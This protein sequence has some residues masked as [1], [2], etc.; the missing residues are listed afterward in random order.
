M[1]LRDI[2]G[3]LL[4]AT[5]AAGS[6]YL[7]STLKS[8]EPAADNGSLATSGFY[9]KSARILGT[10]S[11][12]TPMYEFEAGYAEQQDDQIE[13]R[14]VRINYSTDADVPWTLNADT[15]T[16]GEDRERVILSG[17]VMAVSN[18]GFAGEVTEIRAPHLELQPDKF[19]AETDSRVQIRIGSRSLTATGMLALLQ[20]NQLL[21]KS[22][23]NGKFVP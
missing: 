1:S 16:I 7:A 3:F 23:V 15:A 17:H 4:L 18:V 9:V 19:R 14:D 11:D 10:D 13:F 21:L 5:A 6:W 12:G 20:D 22:D 2:G 8:S